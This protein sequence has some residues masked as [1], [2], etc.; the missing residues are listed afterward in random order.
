MVQK[1][2]LAVTS[3][4]LQYKK[5]D[6]AQ[7]LLAWRSSQSISLL[8]ADPVQ[9]SDVDA[10]R[11]FF[12]EEARLHKAMLGAQCVSLD[13]TE[14]SPTKMRKVLSAASATAATPQR[15]GCTK[16]VMDTVE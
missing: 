2:P 5:D 8:A 16:N 7:V 9:A 15:W 6:F 13:G 1:G 10:Y 11:K 3:R 14:E 4:L 12:N